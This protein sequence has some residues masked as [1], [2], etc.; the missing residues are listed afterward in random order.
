MWG[1]AALSLLVCI[2][3]RYV[4]FSVC[5]VYANPKRLKLVSEG[6]LG[7]LNYYLTLKS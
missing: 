6:R 2:S 1:L 4:M 3:E 7:N 5:L